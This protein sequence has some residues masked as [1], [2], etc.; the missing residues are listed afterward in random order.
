MVNI[1][2]FYFYS[3]AVSLGNS[4]RPAANRDNRKTE[5]NLAFVLIGITTMHLVI[6]HILLS[7]GLMSKFHV[8]MTKNI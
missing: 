8:A 3:A 6:L 1:Y 5:A 4:P 7:T 2:M